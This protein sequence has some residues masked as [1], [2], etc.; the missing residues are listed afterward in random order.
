MTNSFKE[1][2]AECKHNKVAR[3]HFFRVYKYSMNSGGFRFLVS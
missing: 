3:K 1:V 2:V